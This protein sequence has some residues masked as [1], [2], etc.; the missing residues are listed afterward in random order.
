MSIEESEQAPRVGGQR[1]YSTTYALSFSQC[2]PL[3]GAALIS[4][5]DPRERRA[6]V[7]RVAPRR[8]VGAQR[9]EGGNPEVVR[10]AIGGDVEVLSAGVH[11]EPLA[12]GHH[13]RERRA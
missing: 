2:W 13:H 11:L 6:D 10:V 8:D 7:L 4:A 9:V 1:T 12:A 5:E 3:E